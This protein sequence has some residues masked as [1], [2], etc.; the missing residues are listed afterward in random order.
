[1]ISSGWLKVYPIKW[2]RWP[3]VVMGAHF[4][5]PIKHPAPKATTDD[6]K[7]KQA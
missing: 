6:Q 7:P 1:L 2:K 3:A 4:N 5:P